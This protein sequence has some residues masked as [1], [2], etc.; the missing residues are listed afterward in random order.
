M[1]KNLK[2]RVV[3]CSDKN[4]CVYKFS[5]NRTDLE[6]I[7]VDYKPKHNFV[8]VNCRIRNDK[9][10]NS[11]FLYEGFGI[12][13]KGNSH[14]A[15]I[16]HEERLIVLYK[17]KWV[18]FL[19]PNFDHLDSA[20][21]KSIDLKDELEHRKKNINYMLKLFSIEEC[22]KLKYL[23]DDSATSNC[24]FEEVSS[25]LVPKKQKIRDITGF[26]DIMF[27][28]RIANYSDLLYVFPALNIC[29][30]YKSMAIHYKGRFILKNKFYSEDF[31]V[32][33][34]EIFDKIIADGFFPYQSVL[35]MRRSHKVLLNEICDKGASGYVLK[36]K[37]EYTGLPDE[38]LEVLN[39]KLKVDLI[40]T[41]KFAANIEE[42]ASLSGLTAVRVGDILREGGFIK[43]V[44]NKFC[45]VPTDDLLGKLLTPFCT[46]KNVRKSEIVKIIKE[47]ASDHQSRLKECI[48]FLEKICETSGAF[49]CLKD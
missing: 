11:V 3:S 13:P 1:E 27:N 33:R 23:C 41:E 4:I 48:E 45:V 47:S 46:R 35:E 34:K 29:E 14:F 20:E 32:V 18:Y 17:V 38:C 37:E 26:C 25:K 31:Q 2:Y 36:G 24:K 22:V 12:L 6:I 40:L 5:N 30:I 8:R 39:D 19:Q 49:W 28:A 21:E 7:D 43:L 9:A 16:N 10:G 15:K 42:I 44:S